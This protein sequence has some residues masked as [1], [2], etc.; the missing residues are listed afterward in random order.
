MT[1]LYQPA[2]RLTLGWDSQITGNV[3]QDGERRVVCHGPG[4]CGAD[5]L[6]GGRGPPGCQAGEGCRTGAATAG[7]RGSARWGLTGRCCG[8]RRGWTSEP[9]GAGGPGPRARGGRG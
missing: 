4:S 3:I 6:Y 5:G 7:D 2:E 1:N 8:D 9:P